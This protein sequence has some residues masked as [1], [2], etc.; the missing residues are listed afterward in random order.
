[1][2]NKGTVHFSDLCTYHAKIGAAC[3]E[4]QQS[5]LLATGL[6][7]RGQELALF[8]SIQEIMY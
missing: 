4:R 7:D 1:M 8:K 2:K 5:S 6:K 3:T